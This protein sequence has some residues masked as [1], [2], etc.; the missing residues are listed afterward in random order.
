MVKT[1]V[2]SVV[3]TGGRLVTQYIINVCVTL[4]LSGC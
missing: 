4:I 2:T 1:N 3:V